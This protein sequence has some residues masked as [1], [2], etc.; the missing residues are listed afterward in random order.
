M[1]FETLSVIATASG[2]CALLA[3]AARTEFARL[4]LTSLSILVAAIAIA[5]H[6]NLVALP[7][8]A[9]F[10]AVLVFAVFGIVAPAA[11]SRFLPP[12]GTHDDARMRTMTLAILFGLLAGVA[13]FFAARSVPSADATLITLGFVVASTAFALLVSHNDTNGHAVGFLA[14]SSGAAVTFTGVLG[15]TGFFVATVVVG[16]FAVAGAVFLFLCCPERRENAIIETLDSIP[17]P[18]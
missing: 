1:T 4:R 12:S 16:S 6:A 9:Y 13:G 2:I 14:L 7:S 11:I 17:T 15:A 10:Y 18:L 8:S 5:V 3:V